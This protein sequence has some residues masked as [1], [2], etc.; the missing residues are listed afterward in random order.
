MIN[1]AS[2][3]VAATYTVVLSNLLGPPSIP[4]TLTVNSSVQAEFLAGPGARPITSAPIGPIRIGS[5][6]QPITYQWEFDGTNIL[7]ATPPIWC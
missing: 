4:V 5:G 1:P 3:A 2:F 6:T 7:G